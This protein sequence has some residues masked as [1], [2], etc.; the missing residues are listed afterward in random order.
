MAAVVAQQ[1]LSFRLSFHPGF[2]GPPTHRH[3]RSQ[4]FTTVLDTPSSVRSF[5]HFPR[6]STVPDTPPSP[7]FPRSRLLLSSLSFVARDSENFTGSPLA[8][9][10]Q[11]SF[12]LVP[13]TYSLFLPYRARLAAPHPPCP[14]DTPSSVSSLRSFVTTQRAHL[15]RI[16]RAI[17]VFPTR[18]RRFFVVA[19]SRARILSQQPGRTRL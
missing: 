2:R 10:L 9:T 5:F 11:T 18:P 6:L 14:R 1:L 13:F 8:S 16:I 4:R 3:P 12:R 7:H 15:I 17:S 19:P